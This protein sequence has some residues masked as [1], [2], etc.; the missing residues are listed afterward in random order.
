MIQQGS[1]NLRI[2]IEQYTDEFGEVH[3]RFIPEIVKRP[4]AC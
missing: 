4:A 1:L 2:R 3:G